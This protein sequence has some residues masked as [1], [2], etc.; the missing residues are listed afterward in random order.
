[1]ESFKTWSGSQTTPAVSATVKGNIFSE[2]NSYHVNSKEKKNTTELWIWGSIS[3]LYSLHYMVTDCLDVLRGKSLTTSGSPD[4]SLWSCPAPWN[5]HSLLYWGASKSLHF[6]EQTATVPQRQT[7]LLPPQMKVLMD[8]GGHHP[9]RPGPRAVLRRTLTC[10]KSW[11]RHIDPTTNEDH[12]QNV[13]YIP[14]H[15]IC[16]HGRICN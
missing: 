2:G 14:F 7:Q 8:P 11:K 9:T 10:D 16:Q 6:T 13:G 5:E 1:M 4:F 3:V 15:H 12:R